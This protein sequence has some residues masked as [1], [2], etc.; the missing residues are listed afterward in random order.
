[1]RHNPIFGNLRRTL[2]RSRRRTLLDNASRR[3]ILLAKYKVLG[4]H[5][6]VMSKE[7]EM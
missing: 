6:S 2:P 1:M 5:A 4:E 7:L 3:S